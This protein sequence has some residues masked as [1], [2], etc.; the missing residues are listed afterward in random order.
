MPAIVAK[1]TKARSLYWQGWTLSQ[2]AEEL[3]LA[4]TTVASWKS[5][6]K[7]DDAPAIQRAEEGT[8]ERYLRLMAKDKKTG[9]DFK[10]IDLLGRQFERMARIAR[11]CDGGTEADLNPARANPARSTNKKKEKAKNLLTR[12]HVAQLR[13]DL[14]AGLFGHQEGWQASVSQRTRMILKSRQIGAT[15]YFARERLLVAL[16]TGKNQIFISA[17]RAQANIFRN[18]IVQWVQ[19]VCGIELKGDP[20][21]LQRGEDEDGAPLEAVTLY[22]L[23]TNYRTAQGYTGDVVIDECFWIYGF[24]E[25][26][27]VASA[28]ATHKQFTRTLFSTPSTLGHEAY[29]MW[30]GERVNKR[31]ARKDRLKIDIS[32]RTLKVGQVGK[33]GIWR[34]IV[35]VFDAI[36]GGFNLVNVDELQLEYA[37]DE[38]DNL[39]RCLFLDDSLSMFPFAMM[40]RCMVDSWDTWHA[41]YQPYALR[42]YAGEVWLGYDPNASESGTG[43]DA[44]LV[45]VAAPTKPGGKFRIL[46]K[47]RLKGLQFDAQ[48]KAI[49]LMCG[50]YNVT[51]I[52]IDTTGAGKAVEQ[53]VRKWFPTVTAY[54][55]NVQIKSSMVLKAKNV[56][57]AGRL[58]FDAAWQDM[59]SAF[60]AIKPEVTKHGVSYV[61]SR[62]GGVG[63]ADLAFAT[64]HALFFEP[65][66]ITEAPGGTTT[67]E[68]YE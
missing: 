40:R 19:K 11:Y 31:R 52:G 61:A 44:A 22:F 6:H 14:E 29:P 57:S 21:V 58:E 36:E 8:L 5:R 9:Q 13:A 23:G 59:M 34:Q 28:I 68:I 66:D 50:K 26:F 1:R 62:S 7:W 64:M 38:F 54:H 15:W 41:D 51:R 17:S 30:T 47:Q 56:I 39:F 20:M 18:Y 37:A 35:T 2:I 65:L 12:E 49:K 63:H 25:L 67:V 53:L 42:P 16:E 43:D 27:K 10:E 32:H 55:Y 33:D 4:Y 45:A 46:E 3:D 48:A 60:M 24:E